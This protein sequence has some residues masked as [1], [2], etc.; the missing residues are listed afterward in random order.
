MFLGSSLNHTVK[1]CSCKTGAAVGNL[2]RT[3]HLIKNFAQR[4]YCRI[5]SPN[6]NWIKIHKE[7]PTVHGVQA[8]QKRYLVCILSGSNHIIGCKRSQNATDV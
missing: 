5:L 6:Q 7:I 2:P 8:I 1:L 3:A 4:N